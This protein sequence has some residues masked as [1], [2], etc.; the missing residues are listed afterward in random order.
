[1]FEKLKAAGARLFHWNSLRARLV[2]DWHEA[3][4][5]WSMRFNAIGLAN[6]SFV[7]IDPTA[8]LGV[9]N[10]MP[11]E[12]RAVLPHNFLTVLG[13]ILIFL[14]MLSRVV[15]QKPK[16]EPVARND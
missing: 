5:W 3:A 4:R 14:A 16:G 1:M 11:G 10:M 13:G 15:K 2:D 6:L 9:W 8:A 7:S 12:V